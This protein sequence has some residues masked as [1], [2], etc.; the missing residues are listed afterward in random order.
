MIRLHS[1][2]SCNCHTN[3]CIEFDWGSCR[4][5]VDFDQA[6]RRTSSACMPTIISWDAVTFPT[7]SGVAQLRALYWRTAVRCGC[8][9]RVYTC[10]STHS[11]SHW[12]L[13]NARINNEWFYTLLT[14]VATYVS[15]SMFF[16]PDDTNSAQCTALLSK[17][18]MQLLH[19]DNN[20]TGNNNTRV[21]PFR[22]RSM[23]S[24]GTQ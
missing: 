3:N 4:N 6:F 19:C 8:I 9:H 11:I 15:V 12:H 22:N 23:D 16:V 1:H 14:Y 17:E 2:T 10:H 24:N 13:V 20:Q 7:I 5:N 18:C 21:A